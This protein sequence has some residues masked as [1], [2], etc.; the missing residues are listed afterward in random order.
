M[1]MNKKD[2]LVDKCCELYGLS[3]SKFA[4][5]YGLKE[6]TLKQWRTKLPSYG[7]LL[8]EKMIEVYEKDKELEKKTET[9]ARLQE[10]VKEFG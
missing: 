10:I 8:I 6:S 4:E 2:N 7:K 1:L 5:K 3:L 9:M